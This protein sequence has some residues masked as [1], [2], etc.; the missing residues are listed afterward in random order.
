M[1]RL[2]VLLRLSVVLHRGRTDAQIDPRITVQGDAVTLE[3]P[4]RWLEEHRL[5]ELDLKQEIEYLTEVPIKLL[6]ATRDSSRSTH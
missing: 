6:L 1:I 4:Q 3:F 5:T 2:A